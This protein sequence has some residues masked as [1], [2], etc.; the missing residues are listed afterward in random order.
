[1]A[2]TM[3]IKAMNWLLDGGLIPALSEDIWVVAICTNPYLSGL[4]LSNR[5][6]V[7]RNIKTLCKVGVISWDVEVTN[8]GPPGSVSLRD[9]LLPYCSTDP[10]ALAI[11]KV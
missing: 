7:L 3:H 11:L 6:R 5:L 4:N 10:E 1:M 2:F 9:F 8:H